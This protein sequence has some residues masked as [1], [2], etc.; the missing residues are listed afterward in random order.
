[1]HLTAQGSFTSHSFG[2]SGEKDNAS[3]PNAHFEIH[4]HCLP[5]NHPRAEYEFQVMQKT[6]KKEGSTKVKLGSLLTT[7]SAIENTKHQ[8]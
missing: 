6:L 7:V 1:M 3:K 4:I 8:Q 5:Q 2:L